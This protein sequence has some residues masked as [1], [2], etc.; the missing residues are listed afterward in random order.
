MI[1]CIRIYRY[2]KESGDSLFEADCLYDESKGIIECLQVGG[3]SV[4]DREVFAL[5][6]EYL[7]YGYFTQDLSDRC[8][9]HQEITS[10]AYFEMKKLKALKALSF[11]KKCLE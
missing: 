4:D 6:K 10:K 9:C 3:E 11:Y 2:D 5:C 8:S 1:K 7:S